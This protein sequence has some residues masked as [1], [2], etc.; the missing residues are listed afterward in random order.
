MALEQ[1]TT[2]EGVRR[3]L[4]RVGAVVEVSG[5]DQAVGGGVCV[6]GVPPVGGPAEQT[7]ANKAELQCAG[8]HSQTAQSRSTGRTGAPGHGQ[9]QSQGQNQEQSRGQSQGQRQG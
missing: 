9:G 5:W 8:T 3:L 6:P 1:I 7:A 2:G 4:T